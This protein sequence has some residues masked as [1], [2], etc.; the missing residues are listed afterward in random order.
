[1]VKRGILMVWFL[2]F[3]TVLGFC[4]GF[5]YK[6][7]D[8]VGWNVVG[9][10]DYSSWA[11]SKTFQVGDTL[12]FEF[13][14]KDH[15]VLQV[16]RPDFHSCNTAAPIATYATGNDSVVLRRPGHYYYICSFGGHCQAG[17]KVDIRVPKNHQ[18]AE[19]PIGSA[20]P[21]ASSFGPL[22]PSPSPS[23]GE[24]LMLHN[25]LFLLLVFL[26]FNVFN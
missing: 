8:S 21:K 7:G 15:N 19:S 22:A 26:V 5:V 4:K 10:V 2:I 3:T 25:G 12:I 13:D 14:P 6:V 24:A 9:N 16:S 17:Q 23:S 11:S 1:M 18:P 20:V